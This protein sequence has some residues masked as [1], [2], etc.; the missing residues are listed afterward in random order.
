MPKVLVS[1]WLASFLPPGVGSRKLF[2]RRMTIYVGAPSALARLA[3]RPPIFLETGNP[4]KSCLLLTPE[5]QVRVLHG[6]GAA[7]RGRR[8]AS[9]DRR[10]RNSLQQRMKCHSVEQAFLDRCVPHTQKAKFRG[11]PTLIRQPR[12]LAALTP[13]MKSKQPH[14]LL[15]LHAVGRRSVTTCPGCRNFSRKN[16]SARGFT[17]RPRA[18]L[19]SPRRN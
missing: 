14:F 4:R 19:K 18:N 6:E 8:S 12:K 15:P 11:S 16:G 9:R 7:Q 17:P 13:L 1:R 10:R 3:G 5:S 2:R